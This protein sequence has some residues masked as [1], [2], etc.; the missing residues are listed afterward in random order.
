MTAAG[1]DARVV[2]ER[3]GHRLDV[4]VTAA[5]GEV[6]AV[7]GPNGSGKTTLLHALAGLVPLTDGEVRSGGVLWEGEGVRT[8]AQE[9][10]LGV[11]FQ[12]T[13]LFPHLDALDNVAFGPRSR[14][15]ARTA[16][17]TQA[18]AWLERLGVP[19]LAHRRPRE[20]SGGQAQR[21]AVA[22]ALATD[23]QLLLLD[24]PFAALDVTVAMVLR[25]ELRRHL[26]DYPGVA[27]L[28]THD[29]LD[30]L[31]LADR[32]LVLDEGQVVQQGTPDEVARTPASDHVARLVGLNVLRGLARGSR[33]T[34]ADG[35]ELVTITPY[36]G[37]VSAT[38]S[39]AAVTLGVESP[40][41][42]ARNHWAGRVVSV[43]PHG[44]AVRVHLDTAGGL[45]ADVTAE[46]AARLRLAPGA[47]VWASVKATE[48]TVLPQGSAARPPL[49]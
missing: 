16:A 13:L 40:S 44:L 36:E 26:D 25:M 24:E 5:P 15:A 12:E 6:L 32:V 8:R 41:G 29:A 4:H 2:V 38:F 14:G 33:V 3:G 46:S 49:P 21:V 42:S 7:V 30:A 37:P 48:V 20:L 17:R 39:P 47:T 22:R 18:A 45:I 27:L 11:V 31:T 28:V 43:V 34:L 35:H 9:R 23:P 1:L 10:R 19:E